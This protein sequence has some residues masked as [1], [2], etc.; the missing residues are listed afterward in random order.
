[1]TSLLQSG[2]SLK[3]LATFGEESA[4]GMNRTYWWHV[5]WA[6]EPPPFLRW[7]WAWRAARMGTGASLIFGHGETY[8]VIAKQLLEARG[9]AG[10]ECGMGRA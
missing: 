2:R 3:A 10:D 7:K 4:L 6:E 5:I 1:M 9:K 8:Y